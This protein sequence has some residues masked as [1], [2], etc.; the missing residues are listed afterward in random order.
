ME[1]I[2]AH[3]TGG[4]KF[5]TELQTLMLEEIRNQDK[6]RL[7]QLTA[8]CG[9]LEKATALND[10]EIAAGDL[11]QML[12]TLGTRAAPK[13]AAGS[14]SSK[15][16]VHVWERECAC[17]WVK[18]YVLFVVC[19]YAWMYVCMCMGGCI[20][21]V[22]V[23]VCMGMCECVC[24]CNCAMVSDVERPHDRRLTLS[25]SLSLVFSFSIHLPTH[26]LRPQSKKKSKH[27]DT[28][29][30]FTPRLKHLLKDLLGDHLSTDEFPFTNEDVP[31]ELRAY[32]P[33][34]ATQEF[35]KKSKKASRSLKSGAQLSQPTWA[36]KRASHGKSKGKME[37][38]DK[39]HVSGRRVVVFVVGGAS[40]AEVRTVYELTRDYQRQITLGSTEIMWPD[41]YSERLAQLSS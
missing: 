25:L 34:P 8:L 27:T 33:V 19:S 7:I 32:K 39:P 31:K 5:S 24:G 4:R 10:A 3:G 29:D 40:Y 11:E 9:L 41:L 14:S 18:G 17:V 35:S 12:E 6:R 28:P 37:A 20:H 30:S 16:G 13:A 26:H 1:Q 2:I 38:L 23:Y 22:C 15:V 36:S 21:V